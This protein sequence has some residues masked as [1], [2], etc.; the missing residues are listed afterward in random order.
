[1]IIAPGIFSQIKGHSLDVFLLRPPVVCS[2]NPE[3]CQ[4]INM[5]PSAVTAICRMVFCLATNLAFSGK[6][7]VTR[8]RIGTDAIANF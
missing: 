1:M 4:A 8:P 6:A 7:G 5:L 2:N 3:T